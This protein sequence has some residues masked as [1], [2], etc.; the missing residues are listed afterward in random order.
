MANTRIS[1][2]GNEM[3]ARARIALLLLA[4]AGAMGAARAQEY[5]SRPVKLVVPYPPGS[6][7]DQLARVLAQSMQSSLGGTFIVDN[8][9]GALGVIG[10][11]EVARSKPDGYTLL[12]ATNTTHAANLVL[13]NHLPYHPAK[14]F[15]PVARVIVAPLVLL[16]KPDFPARDMREFVALAKSN[17]GG[18]SGGYGSAASL[19]SQAKMKVAGGFTSIDVPYK[20]IPL[21]VTDLLGGQISFTFADLPVALPMIGSG[22]LKSLGVTSPQRIPAAPSLPA[23]AETFPGF[24]VIGWQGVVAPAGTPPEVVR[25]LYDAITSATTQPEARARINALHQ[26]VGLLNPE[27]FAV[28]IDGEI[29]KWAKDAKAARLE[30]Q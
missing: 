2:L 18:L 26:D 17:P 1:Y 9:A 6:G 15:Q 10:T 11:T 30:P 21:A 27:Q 7:P 23:I 12:L 3:G 4:M 8:K 28:F 16:V 13:V 29:M 24:E 5:P 14:D 25:K 22:K 20:G 19:V